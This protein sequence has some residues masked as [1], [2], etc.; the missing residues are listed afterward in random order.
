MDG[1]AAHLR[2]GDGDRVGTVLLKTRSE[3]DRESG[4]QAEC[5]QPV[6][7]FALAAAFLD[8]RERLSKSSLFGANFE[9]GQKHVE[10]EETQWEK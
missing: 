4:A 9:S 2:T 10:Q 5:R 3:H 1:R 6:R 8:E 7:A